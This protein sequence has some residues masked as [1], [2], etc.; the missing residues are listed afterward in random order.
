M[1]DPSS[2][3]V[4]DIDRCISLAG[5]TVNIYSVTLL[6]RQKWPSFY[7]VLKLFL[8]GCRRLIDMFVRTSTLS[9]NL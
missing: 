5:S 2:P 3:L 7:S 9:I 4:F 1:P 8:K 6:Y